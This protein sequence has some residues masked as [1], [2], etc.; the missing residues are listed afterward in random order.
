MEAQVER[1]SRSRIELTVKARSQF[2]ERRCI[3]KV[4]FV[5]IAQWISCL[6]DSSFLVIDELIP[7][8]LIFLI[9]F[10]IHAALR[11]MWKLSCQYLQMLL[12]QTYG[13]P[14][15][16]LRMHLKM[17]HC[18]GKSNPF[19][20]ARFEYGFKL[21]S[22]RRLLHVYALCMTAINTAGFAM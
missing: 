6:L 10:L 12:I 13:L 14:W 18:F 11:R 15:D 19:Q 20:V 16:L 5:V 2:K 3:F 8:S 1:H 4:S 7:E 21:F 17:M 9:G 22:F